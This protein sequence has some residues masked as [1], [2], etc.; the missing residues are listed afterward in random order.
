M[1]ANGIKVD[2]QLIMR[3][4][5]NPGGPFV[6]TKFLVSKRGKQKSKCQTDAV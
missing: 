3:W 5:D 4:R 1:V 2:N 6:I